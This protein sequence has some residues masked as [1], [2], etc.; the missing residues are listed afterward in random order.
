M[1]RSRRTPTSSE[2]SEARFR[3]LVDDHADVVYRVAYSVVRDEH[4]AEDVVQETIIKA[5][6]HLPTWRGEGSLRGWVLSIAHNTA[7]SYLR[8]LHDTAVDP[9]LL[10]ERAS[11]DDVER[12]AVAR[13]DL[14]L[15][16]S[17]LGELDE[18]SRSVVVM[19]DLEG[20][21]YQDIADALGVPLATVKTRLLRAR[22]ELHRVVASGASP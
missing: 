12:G 17:A 4:L 20:L 3:A 10:P 9:A 18:L 19:R 6:Q 11:V 5:W 7:V 8:R 16:F 15:L 13:D 22:R 2:T 1:L 14:D 21:A